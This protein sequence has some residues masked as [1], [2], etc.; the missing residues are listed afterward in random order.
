MKMEQAS[1]RIRRPMPAGSAPS[2]SQSL[3]HQGPTKRRDFFAYTLA[4]SALAAGAAAQ[5]A[6][7]IQADSDFELSKFTMFAD[8]AGAAET[9]ATRVLPLI[10]IQI[11]DTGTG[12]ALFSSPLPIPAI[13][14]DG[15][16]PF[17]LPVPKIFSANASVAIQVSNFSAATTYNLR[18]LLIGAKIFTY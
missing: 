11:T 10:T 6:I 15:R 16:I 14:G 1:L 13:M 3:V 9:E 2:P 4:F 18:L 5:G 12:R 17:I 8:I 7:Q